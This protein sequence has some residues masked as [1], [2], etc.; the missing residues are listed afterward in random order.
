MGLSN[1]IYDSW[2]K[3][4][5]FKKYSGIV[6]MLERAKVDLKGKMLDVGIGTGLFEEYLKGQG[7]SPEVV[8]VDTDQ[9]MM[10]QAKKKG[11][12]VVPAS[13]EKLPFE[14]E[15]FDFVA[16]MDTIHA[17]KDQEKAM[18]EMLRV[19]KPHKYFLLSHFCNPFTKNDVAKKLEELTE[20]MNVIDRKL[21][22]QSDS[23]IAVTFLI[24]K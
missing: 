21:V 22:G 19:L 20:G 1:L 24:K 18:Q 14:D 12:N 15:S 23:E 17:V 13:A 3:E 16:C 11:F 10:R 4:A 6:P 9:Q 5:Q 8:G 7:I 2:M